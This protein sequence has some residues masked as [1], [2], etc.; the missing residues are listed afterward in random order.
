MK[1]NLASSNKWTERFC[2]VSHKSFNL[3]DCTRYTSHQLY[4]V[5]CDRDVIFNAN[6]QKEGTK[7]LVTHE[8][9]QKQE[10]FKDLK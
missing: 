5:C 1:V 2:G 10:A 4:A 3:L 7:W 8:N 6:L 9:S